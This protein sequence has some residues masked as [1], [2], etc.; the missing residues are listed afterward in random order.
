[1]FT[2][3]ID[4]RQMDELSKIKIVHHVFRVHPLYW[5]SKKKFKLDYFCLRTPK[6]DTGSVGAAP[7]KPPMFCAMNDR[8]LTCMQLQ[9][10]LMRLFGRCDLN[11]SVRGRVSSAR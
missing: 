10:R 3:I 4:V 9:L 11:S 2:D 8:A 5:V 7:G 6:I 1:M